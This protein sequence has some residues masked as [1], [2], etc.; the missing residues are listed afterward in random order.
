M[1]FCVGVSVCVY[2]GEFYTFSGTQVYSEAT[3]TSEI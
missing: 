1:R 2:V 3:H